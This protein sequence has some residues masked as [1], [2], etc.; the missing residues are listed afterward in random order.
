MDR[1]TNKNHGGLNWRKYAPGEGNMLGSAWAPSSWMAG[2]DL[3]EGIGGYDYHMLNLTEGKAWNASRD[4]K[5]SAKKF[6]STGEKVNIPGKAYPL[7]TPLSTA[8]RYSVANKLMRGGSYVGKGDKPLL[9]VLWNVAFDAKDGATIPG[10]IAGDMHGPLQSVADGALR[11]YSRTG[12]YKYNSLNSIAGYLDKGKALRAAGAESVQLTRIGAA[13]RGAFR[14]GG[15][16]LTAYNWGTMAYYG[17]KGAYKLGEA[18]YY[19]APMAAYKNVARQLGRPAFSSG[20]ASLLTG[21]PASNRMRAVQAIQGSR[22]NARS[23][24]GGEASLLSGHFG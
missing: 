18:Y 23:A 19:K 6:R 20:D 9:D 5:P 13:A 11:G 24:L 1:F 14:V 22:L 3:I 7:D 15:A 17:G 16:A 21:I 4:L 2:M 12:G 8:D 10:M